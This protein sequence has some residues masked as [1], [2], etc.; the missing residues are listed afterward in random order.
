MPTT[1]SVNQRVKDIVGSTTL[2]I[3]ARAKELQSQGKDIINF[4]AGEPDH[5]TPEEI[6]DSGIKAIQTGF[7]KYTPTSGTN[8]LKEAICQ[9]FL[10][11]NNLKYNPSQIVVSCGAKHSIYN[12]IQ[13]LVDSGD[14]VLL[15]APYWVSYPEMIKLAGGQIKILETTA[16]HKFKITPELLGENI[17]SKSKLLI[18]NSPSNPTGMV[19]LKKELEAIAEICVRSQVYVIS[20]EI[21]EKLIYDSNKYTSIGSLG[22]DIFDLTFTVNGVSKAFA[23]TGWRIGYCAGS[24]EIMEYI[25]K[26]QDHSTSNPTSISQVAAVQ[27]L[28]S[29]EGSISQMCQIFQERRD[30]MVSLL[31]NAPRIKFVPPQGAFY[32]FCDTSSLGDSNQLVKRILDEVNVAVIPGDG[33]GAPGFIRLSFAT[34]QEKIKEGI[35]RIIQ[36]IEKETKNGY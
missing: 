32:V 13:V 4:A 31:N 6:K 30:L 18:L 35:K 36:W 24:Q 11:D 2:E 25:K 5:D 28:K 29:P 9:K 27:A 23:M 19:Y 16:K 21:Y 17:T 26:F 3:T 15:P 1:L 34:S 10:K 14:E 8:E 12:L 22:K 7:T 20:D 33:F